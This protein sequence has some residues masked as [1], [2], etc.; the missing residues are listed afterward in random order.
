[1]SSH[2]AAKQ[3]PIENEITHNEGNKW[4]DKSF[5]SARHAKHGRYPQPVLHAVK[6]L[7][8]QP[9]SS[10]PRK[11]TERTIRRKMYDV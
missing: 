10:G 4:L 5:N 1:M 2:L 9:L 3:K 11:T 7:R 8:Q 6:L